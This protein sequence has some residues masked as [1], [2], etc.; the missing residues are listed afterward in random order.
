MEIGIDRVLGV[1]GLLSGLAG[2]WLAF[3]FY[4]KTIRTKVLAIAHT[5]PLPLM[6]PVADIGAYYLEAEQKSLS[7]V[8]VLFWNRGTAPIESDDFINA[9]SIRSKDKILLVK[10]KDKDAAATA[11]LDSENKTLKII[12]LRPD[13]AIVMQI[14]ST[15]LEYRADLSVEMK[16]SDMSVRLG[17]TRPVVAAAI[18]AL[19]GLA[20]FFLMMIFVSA[21]DFGFR[22][23]GWLRAAIEFGFFVLTLAI[24]FL[25][26]A[27]MNKILEKYF[28]ARTSPV[29][30]RFFAMQIALSDA[31]QTWTALKTKVEKAMQD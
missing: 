8:F 14:D 18:S 1:L 10:I 27:I 30:W 17:W 28:M 11:D 25:I 16:T 26:A 22:G 13:E 12:L 4:Q 15:D 24:A 5:N 19:S 3:Y 2:L 7:R 9:I 21:P 20:V 31:L 29:A 23:V 6:P